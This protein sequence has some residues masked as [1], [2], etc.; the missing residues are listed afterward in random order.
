MSHLFESIKVLNGRVRNLRYHQERVDR[1][2][3][4]LSSKGSINLRKYI[5]DISLPETGIHKLRV[6]YNTVDQSISHRIT[7]YVEKP[8]RSLRLVETTHSYSHKYEDR[9]FIN[10]AY[11]QKQVA[12]DILFVTN[13][14]IKDTSYC[15]VAFYN[16]KDWLTPKDP[17]L[18]GTMRAQLMSR[19]IIKEFEIKVEDLG[20]F[21]KCRLFNAMIN[22]SARKEVGMDKISPIY[23][24]F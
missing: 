5:R 24:P 13:N 6:S 19:G 14:I 9:E 23:S 4:E 12:D 20:G 1:A 11:V 16:G 10:K 3:T 2:Y 7:P 18:C 17:L 21:T 8:I 15:N 22:W